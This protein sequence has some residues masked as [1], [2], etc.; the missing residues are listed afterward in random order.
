MAFGIW[1]DFERAAAPECF[2]AALSATMI[3]EGW[4]QQ[5]FV[6]RRKVWALFSVH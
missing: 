6:A 4:V 5:S 2:T 3:K 1:F